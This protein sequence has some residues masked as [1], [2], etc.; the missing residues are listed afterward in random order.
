MRVGG[1]L[2]LRQIVTWPC[3]GT[4]R[5]IAHREGNRSGSGSVTIEETDSVKGGKTI[6]R[7]DSPKVLNAARA[8]GRAKQ[9]VRYVERCHGPNAGR[10]LSQHQKC[11][12]HSQRR[13][14]ND[15]QAVWQ[16][17]AH[18]EL[19]SLRM[20]AREKAPGPPQVLITRKSQPANIT[21]QSRTRI[22][23]VG[24]RLLHQQ[25]AQ[26]PRSASDLDCL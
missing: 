2:K 7:S 25:G 8:D 1:V 12:S 14:I 11:R 13:D 24:C 4:I 21:K 15:R 6:K 17:H 23:I 16:G 26:I 20:T 10:R 3:A 5:A 18:V 9:Q 22:V 19:V